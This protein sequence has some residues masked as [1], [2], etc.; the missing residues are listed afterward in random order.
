MGNGFS[1]FASTNINQTQ[2]SSINQTCN[3][4]AHNLI[5]DVTITAID[6]HVGD[7][8]LSS[9]LNVGR[10]DCVM[11]AVTTATA[12]AAV[13]NTAEAQ[14]QSL[15]YQL[16]SNNIN[17][18]QITAVQSFQQSIINQSCQ[19][20]TEAAVKDLFLTFIDSS[21]GN[22]KVTSQSQID[23]ISC[24]LTASSYQSAAATVKNSASGKI[25]VSCCGFDLG[26]LIP[27]VLG[28]VALVVV[29][30]MAASKQS[31]SSSGGQVDPSTAF[32]QALQAGRGGASQPPLYGPPRPPSSSM[33][34]TRATVV[35]VSSTTGAIKA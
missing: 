23:S 1:S 24:N 21:T 8:T 15:P 10:M 27:V 12:Q 32:I 20:V 6:S 19:E 35:P 30:K 7:I 5:E 3:E 4:S 22:I 11:D 2:I 25:S 34:G 16:D 26:M 18:S 28:L 31:S 17:I 33:G 13:T 14:I 29:S 9:T